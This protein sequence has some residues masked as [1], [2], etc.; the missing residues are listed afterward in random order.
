MGTAS[1]VIGLILIGLGIYV[2]FVMPTFPDSQ[3][4]AID[5]FIGKLL[6]STPL[7]VIGA[8]LLRKFKRDFKK[9]QAQRKNGN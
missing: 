6:W 4:D 7:F 5:D 8:F 3:E 1:Y 2:L 9:E